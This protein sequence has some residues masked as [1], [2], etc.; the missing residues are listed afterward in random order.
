[1]VTG[2]RWRQLADQ[3]RSEIVGGGRAPGSKLPSLVEQDTAG[4]SQTTT[5]RAYRELAAEGLV[6]TAHGSGSYVA[7]PLPDARNALSL[8]DHEQR[9]RD[10][11][12]RLKAL[13]S[14]S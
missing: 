5:L 7:D 6:V 11:E 14:Q 1:M 10:L 13:E 4:Y 3:L 12:A 2:P 9:L 8:E